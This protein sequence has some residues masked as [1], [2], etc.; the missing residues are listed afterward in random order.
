PLGER[1]RAAPAPG[2][3]VGP[4]SIRSVLATAAAVITVN[5][6]LAGAALLLGRPVVHLGRAVWGVSGVATP[7]TLGALP[8]ALARALRDERPSLR[9]RCLTR[10][11]RQDHVWCDRD[12]PDRNGLL[13]LLQ[14]IER[15]CGHHAGRGDRV[16]YRPGPAWPLGA[17]S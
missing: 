13:G 8:E 5:H 3:V 16:V 14:R 11:L 12:A 6:P 4:S 2:A 10:L 17:P 9:D 7:S 1:L 15:A